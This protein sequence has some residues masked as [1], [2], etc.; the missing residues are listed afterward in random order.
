[1]MGKNHAR[2]LSNLDGVD[3][4]AIADEDPSHHLESNKATFVESVDQI[5]QFNLDYCF[6]A[7]P[8]ALHEE[9][10]MKLA[11]SSIHTLMEKPLAADY[12]SA[13]RLTEEY[14]K[15]N[16][17]GAVGHIERYNASIQQAKKRI[18]NGELG[19]IYQVA[20]RRQNPFPKRIL[21]VGV[22]RDLA[23]H[24]IDLTLWITGQDYSEINTQKMSLPG[25]IF[26]DLVSIN[27]KLSGGIIANHLI[28]WV[29]P[30]KERL[31]VIT[32]SKGAFICDTL[33]SDLTFYSGAA[34]ENHWIELANFRGTSEGDVIKYS[35]SK[36]EPLRREH[37]N[38][39]DAVL[40]KES[41]IV[42]MRQGLNVVSVADRI[43]S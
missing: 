25:R 31:I 28:N 15:R 40:R 19:E 32:G 18:I 21:D 4:V 9:V 24:D 3:L 13:L 2:V 8:T 1:M 38:F 26:E 35:F 36:P 27:A 22:V 16:L 23:T 43:L 14:E 7:V 12:A 29:T 30:F 41:E 39:R 20:T 37:E 10:G 34:T 33:T 17:I 11:A 6:V 5:V 42:T